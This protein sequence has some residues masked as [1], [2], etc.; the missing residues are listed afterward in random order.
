[1]KIKTR[2]PLMVGNQMGMSNVSE[3]SNE[4]RRLGGAWS[5]HEIQSRND[6]LC[7]PYDWT[8]KWTLLTAEQIQDQLRE[9]WK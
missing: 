4:Q 2:T 3:W 1:M 7:A 9:F 5:K 8:P 6:Y